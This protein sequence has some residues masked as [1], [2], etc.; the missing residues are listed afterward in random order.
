MP[1]DVETLQKLLL[2]KEKKIQ[3][4]IV[5]NLSLKNSVPCDSIEELEVELDENAE[6]IDL[7][8]FEGDL[9]DD[10]EG[11]SFPNLGENVNQGDFMNIL[12]MLLTQGTQGTYGHQNPSLNPNENEEEDGDDQEEG[13]DKEDII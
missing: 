2:E 13:D 6:T 10:D 3:E 5:E 4:L 9:D 12:K 7:K 1:D 8:H 11:E